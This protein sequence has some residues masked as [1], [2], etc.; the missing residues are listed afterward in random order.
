MVLPIRLTADAFVVAIALAAIR[1]DPP[2]AQVATGSH[3]GV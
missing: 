2:T 3:A 1:Q